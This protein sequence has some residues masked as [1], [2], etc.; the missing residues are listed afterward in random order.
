HLVRPAVSKLRHGISRLA[1]RSIK[2]GSKFR[3]VRKNRNIRQTSFVESL[4]NRGDAPIH[5]V[6]RSNHV[7]PSSGQGNRSPREQ[8]QSRIVHDFVFARG[9]RWMCHRRSERLRRSEE[10]RVGKGE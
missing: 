4:A 9:R 5:H 2:T 7:D 3:G 10:R 8:L 1:K 6:R